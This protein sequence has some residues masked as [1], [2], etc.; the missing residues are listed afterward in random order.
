MVNILVPTDFSELSNNATKFAIKIANKLNG[1]VTLIH[2]MTA[3]TPVRASMQERIQ[4]IEK[5]L[6]EEANENLEAVAHSFARQV[7][8]TEPI[9]RKIARGSGSFEETL[10]KEAKKLRAGLIIM[11]THGASGLKKVMMGSNTTA[12]IGSSTIPVLA[13][14]KAGEFKSFR[15]VIYASNLKN[16]EKELKLLIPYVEKFNATLHLVHVAPSGDK[17]EALEEKIA[18]IVDKAGYKKI[19]TMVLVD[20]DVDA[21]LAQYINISKAEL[22]AMFTRKL[23][24]YE[25]LF[26]RSV[27]RRMAFHSTIPLLAFKQ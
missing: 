23:S 5:E 15:N 12:V 6:I 22:L 14:P 10:K 8:F 19:V 21:A 27:T 25:K 26:D 17:V 9:R 11:G 7:R 4:K 13:I 3:V 16:T 1:T 20:E 2:V 18:K 24:F